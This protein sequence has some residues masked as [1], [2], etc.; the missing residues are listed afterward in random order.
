MATRTTKTGS[1][2]AMQNDR[3]TPPIVV[4][5][6]ESVA[7][8]RGIEVD[9]LRPLGYSL[10]PDALERLIDSST[11]PVEVSFELYGCTVHV[12]ADGNVDARPTDGSP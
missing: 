3:E 9:A 8:A 7:D 10:D 6:V 12:D 2:N 5:I 4:E 1:D 11:V